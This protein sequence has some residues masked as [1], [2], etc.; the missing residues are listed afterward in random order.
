[1]EVYRKEQNREERIRRLELRRLEERFRNELMDDE[2]RM[3][4]R[5]TIL[6]L[7]RAA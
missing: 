3:E 1:M 6:R 7:R 4:L 2:K 5:D